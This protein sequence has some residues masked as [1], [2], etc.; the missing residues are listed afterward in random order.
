MHRSNDPFCPLR[1]PNDCAV[2][3]DWSLR[4]LA[5]SVRRVFRLP[6]FQPA[7]VTCGC[8]VGDAHRRCLSW[9]FNSTGGVD[10]GLFLLPRMGVLARADS[11]YLR[12]VSRSECR[13]AATFRAG[14]FQNSVSNR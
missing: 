11:I 9:S 1:S 14:D 4:H 13:T 12:M 8:Q 6:I 2:D 5:A 7:G 3:P 10:A